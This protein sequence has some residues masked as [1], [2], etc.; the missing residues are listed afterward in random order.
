MKNVEISKATGG[1]IPEIVNL[2]RT[3]DFALTR[4]PWLEWKYFDNPVGT[5]AM[6]KIL[7][8][9]ELVG[10]VAIMPQLFY[11][12]GKPVIGLQTVDGLLGHQVRGKGFFN[13]LMHFLSGQKPDDV[14]DKCFYLSFPSLAVSI[15]A[16]E[17]AGW[18]KLA[19]FELTTAVLNPEA[20]FGKR[21]MA[22]VGRALSLPWRI[23]KNSLLTA[24]TREIITEEIT[25]S[26]PGFNTYLP[27]G[28]VAGDRSADFMNWRIARNPRDQMKMLAF[29]K[30]GQ[31][32][33]YAICK[34]IGRTAEVSEL[35]A[36]RGVAKSATAALLRYIDR[37]GL[38][39]SVDFWTLGNASSSIRPTG[40]GF[41][42]RKF[43]GALFVNHF[44]RCH[45]P[46]APD[47]WLVSY[48]DSDW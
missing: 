12:S 8:N 22:A 41:F 37:K 38:A 21:N 16:H 10:A 26:L 15:K 1:D 34:F 45:L 2:F 40:V 29:Q 5:A 30:S 36:S 48:L 43:T 35:R 6:F 24:R 31:P 27:G 47:K 9:S 7:K 4:R 17:N 28:R 39:D 25:G 46:E 32:V 33:G 3:Y 14:P 19:N 11:F 23:I 44:R 42:R 20:L 18:R 13:E